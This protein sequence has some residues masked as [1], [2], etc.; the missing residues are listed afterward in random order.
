MPSKPFP[1]ASGKLIILLGQKNL[2]GIP[3]R[4][5]HSKQL[6]KSGLATDY[7]VY[8]RADAAATGFTGSSNSPDPYGV[9]A[10]DLVKGAQWTD[11]ASLY[12][13]LDVIGAYESTEH[14][15]RPLDTNRPVGYPSPEPRRF[16]MLSKPEGKSHAEAMAYWLSQHPRFCL[17]HHTGMASYTQNHIDRSLLPGSPPLDGFADISYWNDDAF[18]FGH[19]SRPDS[20]ELMLNDC[21]HFRSTSCVVPVTEWIIVRPQ[22][23]RDAEMTPA[24]NY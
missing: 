17:T 14:V 16:A 6:A 13:N 9:F 8:I 22:C 3:L 12:D 4:N 19:F 7:R 11:I 20:M 10:V 18:R 15:I 1:S 5:A 21:R 24:E 23:W 2:D